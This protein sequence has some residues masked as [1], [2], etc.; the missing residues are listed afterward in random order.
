VKLIVGLGNP[1]KEYELTPHNLGF[2]A[3]DRLAD[4]FGVEVRNRQ[5]H[6]L[7]ARAEIAGRVH[8]GTG[9]LARPGRAKLDS[10]LVEA[11]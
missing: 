1:G 7:T 8:V 2:L 6:A 3:I 5:C 9:A 10:V 4:E 11:N